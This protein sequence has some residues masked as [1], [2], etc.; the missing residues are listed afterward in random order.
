MMDMTMIL[1][2]PDEKP[3]DRICHDGGFVGIFR[4]IACVGDS[5]AS[6][7]FETVD[8]DGTKH[9]HDR[10]DYS[11]G[12]F[13]ARMAGSR[14][15]NFSRGGM[16][17]KGYNESWAESQGYWDPALAAHAY[18]VALGVNDL[19][20]RGWEIGSEAD[21]CL[22]DYRK[23]ADTF[24]GHFAAIL[25]R[26]REIS[27]E[28]KFF[29]VTMPPQPEVRAGKEDRIAAHAALMH[30]FA[31]M[32]PGTY[33]V[34]L[35]VYGPAY[36]G[37]EFRRA[38]FLHGHFTPMGYALSAKLIVSYIDYIIRHNAADFKEIGLLGREE[39]LADG[40]YETIL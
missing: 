8:E 17:A 18:I 21:V 23:N 28:A 6:G 36:D 3:L 25:Q 40:A 37:E 5:L 16:T 29:L 4:K 15:Y 26:Y 14:V 11:W 10:F 27:P 22:D 2:T 9:Y 13:L 12:Q 24:A 30:R 38:F 39:K 19:L 7:E 35:N 31:E 1:G 33:V 34:D 20:N 32:F